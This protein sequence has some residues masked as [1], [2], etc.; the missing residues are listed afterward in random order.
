MRFFKNASKTQYKLKEE[1]NRV[2]L[3]ERAQKNVSIQTKKKSDD[4]VQ[5]K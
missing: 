5:K 2:I 3:R 4:W 1:K